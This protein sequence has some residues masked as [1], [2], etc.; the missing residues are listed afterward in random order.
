VSADEPIASFQYKNGKHDEVL[1]FLK[2]TRSELRMLRMV[3]VWRNRVRVLDVNRDA[4][5]VLGLGY[6]DADIVAVLDTVNTVYR[7]DVIHQETDAEFKQFKTGRRYTWAA[8]RVMALADER[9]TPSPDE[10]QVA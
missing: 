6:P 2:R 3:R 4:F 8:D 1:E 10:R 7:R 9:W 5:E